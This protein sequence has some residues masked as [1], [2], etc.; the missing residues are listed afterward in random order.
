MWGI[1]KLGLCHDTLLPSD[2]L[3]G[4]I[5]HMLFSCAE[6]QAEQPGAMGLLVQTLK[7]SDWRDMAQEERAVLELNHHKY[8]DGIQHT[9]LAPGD[10]APPGP[11]ASPSPEPAL[12]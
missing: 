5:R 12:G 7:Q 8:Q 9:S 4:H 11:S 10:L 6:L 2:D 3:D 1:P